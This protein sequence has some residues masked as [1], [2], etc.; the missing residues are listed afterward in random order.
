MNSKLHVCVCVLGF[1]VSTLFLPQPTIA[2]DSPA[3][4]LTL[5][6]RSAFYEG[7]YNDAEVYFRQ[8]VA[9][10]E[11]RSD[12]LPEDILI[13]RGD[14]AWVLVV[15]GSYGEAERLLDSALRSLPSSG[16][17]SCRHST[18]I[19]SHLGTVYQKTGRY[20]RAEK[21]F[22]LAL[23]QAERCVPWYTQAALNNLGILYGETGRMKQAIAPLER[24]LALIEKQRKTPETQ[25]VLGQTL[26][27]L[28]AVQQALGNFSAAEQLL[29][30][31]IPI[32]EQLLEGNYR[33]LAA[34][35][36]SVAVEE[37]GQ[38]HHQQGKLD[39]AENE[40]VRAKDIEIMRGLGGRRLSKLSFELADVLASKGNYDGAKAQYEQA[41]QQG[42]KDSALTAT[43]MER[44]SRLLHI[45]K[46]DDQAAEIEFRAKKIRA[47]LAYTTSVK[48]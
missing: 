8:S 33:G 26:T 45:M 2:E 40:F 44:F 32:L 38:L 28:V 34:G 4:E 24:S 35:F 11:A 10:L 47:A 29:A 43:I 39:Q 41:L 5:L 16:A 31:A 46:A 37:F 18:I 21:L 13:A 19:L 12:S 30:R 7:R 23:K 27:S 14:L 1:V 3:E 48:K 6:G 20:A 42:D 25:L 17:Q 22:K 15:K 9:R 36:L